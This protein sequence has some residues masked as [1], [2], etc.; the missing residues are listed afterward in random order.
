MNSKVSALVIVV[1]TVGLFVGPT[2]RAACMDDVTAAEEQA[3]NIADVK[4][5]KKAKEDLKAAKE[6]AANYDEAGCIAKLNEAMKR[7]N[8]GSEPPGQWGVSP[9]FGGHERDR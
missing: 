5:K 4:E 6:A 1:L 3:K 9:Y 7:I 8:K 2:A